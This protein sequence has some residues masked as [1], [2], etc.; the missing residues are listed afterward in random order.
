MTKA[1]L[2]ER[3]AR[4][5]DLPPDTTKKC[6]AEILDIAFD[7]L[8]AYFKRARITRTQS[9][10]F[11]FPGFGTFT[12]KRRSARRG[13]NPRTLEPIEIEASYTLDFKPGSDL[14][15]AMNPQRGATVKAGARKKKTAQKGRGRAKTAAGGPR[16]GS[17]GRRKKTK[18][19]K[20]KRR[21]LEPGGAGAVR[22]VDGRKLTP[23]DED[24]EL[25]ALFDDDC[26]FEEHGDELPEAPLQRVRPRG[27]S[28]TR[29]RTG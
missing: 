12:K 20:A 2:I 14:R 18:R 10:R 4:S 8:A 23:R 25:D 29:R 1:E 11:T 5:R 28:T 24:A 22:T 3:I 9:P 27:Q 7:E 15:A 19:G 17:R 16:D 13:V 26:L 21:L 6:I